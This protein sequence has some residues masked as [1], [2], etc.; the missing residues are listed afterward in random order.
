MAVHYQIGLSLAGFDFRKYQTRIGAEFKAAAASPPRTAYE[1]KIRERA[2]ELLSL[3]DS[4]D[5]FDARVRKYQGFP[6]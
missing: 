4:R 3:M 2:G 6:E 1:K 5:A